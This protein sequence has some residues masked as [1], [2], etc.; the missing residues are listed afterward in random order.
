MG[1][2]DTPEKVLMLRSKADAAYR[3]IQTLTQDIK[4]K[5]CNNNEL[6]NSVS[7]LLKTVLNDLN[8]IQSN[9]QGMLCI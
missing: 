7:E 8:E 2:W 1:V 6:L 5:K 4:D 3:N 9:E